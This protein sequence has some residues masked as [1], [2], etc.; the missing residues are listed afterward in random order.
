MKINPTD[1]KKPI[2]SLHEIDIK[3]G[4]AVFFEGNSFI[5]KIIK[6]VT[7]GE[8][9]HVASVINLHPRILISHATRKGVIIESLEE[10]MRNYNG[11]VFIA[12]L[13]DAMRKNFNE[14]KFLDHVYSHVGC[15]YNYTEA[16]KLGIKCL[17]YKLI[18]KKR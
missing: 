2:T 14:E 16:I 3:I 6:W 7:D 12:P 4:D 5:S 9:S 10:V 15:K 11:S 18:G 17:Y 13:S 8:V 1:S